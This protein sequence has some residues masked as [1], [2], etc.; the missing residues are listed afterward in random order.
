MK[1]YLSIFIV[2]LFLVPILGTEFM[3][4]VWEWQDSNKTLRVFK[5]ALPYIVYDA[6]NKYLSIIDTSN[7]ASIE[8]DTK[9]RS[10]NFVLN[11]SYVQNW[12]YR[13]TWGLTCSIVPGVDTTADG[14]TGEED[15]LIFYPR[16]YLGPEVGWIQGVALVW[17]AAVDVN[18]GTADSTTTYLMAHR[19]SAKIWFWKTNPADTLL[20]GFPYNIVSIQGGIYGDSTDVRVEMNLFRY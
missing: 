8:T 6:D 16:Y 15:S 13:G 20:Q 3:G 7:Y 10:R 12:E 4:R 18:T 9:F 5:S 11:S 14:G 17:R 19:D 2:L 1:K